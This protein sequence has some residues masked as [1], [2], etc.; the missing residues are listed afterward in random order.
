MKLPSLA[1]AVLGILLAFS[2]Q[3]QPETVH[4]EYDAAGNR[5]ARFVFRSMNADETDSL[6][7]VVDN[8]R[9]WWE[10]PTEEKATQEEPSDSF[11]LYPNPTRDHVIIDNASLNV[12]GDWTYEIYNPEGL[13]MK[14]GKTRRFPVE[15]DF[16][17]FAP[18]NYY[19]RITNEKRATNFSIIK[20]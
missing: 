17:S 18:G 14:N 12:E 10:E 7:Q 15:I 5:K 20:L 3:A 8:F 11:K 16:R 4:F 9:D 19:L 1:V 2:A 6:S 13:L